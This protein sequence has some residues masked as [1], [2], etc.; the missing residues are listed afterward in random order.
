MS[1]TIVKF[2]QFEFTIVN[3]NHNSASVSIRFTILLALEFEIFFRL[4]AVDLYINKTNFGH[5]Y[6]IK[7]VIID[8][9]KSMF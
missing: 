4:A 7:I 3:W 8:R 1:F 5:F 2:L 9:D 6:T